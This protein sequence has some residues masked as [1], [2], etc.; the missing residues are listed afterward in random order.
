MTEFVDFLQEV[1]RNFGSVQARKMFSGYGLYRDGVMF[2]LV[3][4]ETL[5][6]KADKTIAHYF[7]AKGLAQFEYTRGDKVVKM[8]YYVAPEEIFDDPEEAA[9]W[10][11]LSFEV[12]FRSKKRTKKNGF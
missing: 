1:F 11:R 7:E 4:D 9:K 8:S 12:A 10:A 5:Y 2:G 3:A 6:L